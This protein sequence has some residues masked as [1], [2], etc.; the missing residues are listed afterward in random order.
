ME[1][2]VQAISTIGFPIVACLGGAMFIYQNNKEERVENTKREEKFFEQIDKFNATIN[3]I[4]VTL[5]GLNIRLEKIEE[6]VEGK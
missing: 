5:K 4:N 3:D 6:K 2:I 1:D